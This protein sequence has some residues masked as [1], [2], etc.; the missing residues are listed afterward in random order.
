YNTP[1]EGMTLW[2]LPQTGAGPVALA[3]VRSCE[4]ELEGEETGG[5]RLTDLE[6]KHPASIM[7]V[8]RNR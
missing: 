5:I 2:H 3:K 1:G 7:V 4:W 6:A 8:P